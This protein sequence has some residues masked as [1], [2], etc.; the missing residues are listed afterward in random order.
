M[1][2]D[3]HICNHFGILI[4]LCRIRGYLLTEG[5]SIY[6][7][8]NHTII[9]TNFDHIKCNRSRYPLNKSIPGNLSVLIYFFRTIT[10]SVI[11]LNDGFRIQTIYFSISTSSQK[12]ASLY[13]YLSHWLWCFFCLIII[14]L[15]NIS[16]NVPSYPIPS[17]MMI[18]KSILK[19]QF[20]KDLALCSS[21]SSFTRE[22]PLPI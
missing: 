4:S 11:Y 13:R 3:Q 22:K 9:I 8:K 1:Q 17:T 12:L 18:Y 16:H 20:P 2:L 15:L 7:L 6:H 19:V 21:V 5:L 10:L 14:Y